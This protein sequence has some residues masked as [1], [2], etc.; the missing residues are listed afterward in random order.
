MDYHAVPPP[1][2][3]GAGF[4]KRQDLCQQDSERVSRTTPGT[5][6][7]GQ[8]EAAGASSSRRPVAA[9]GP[10]SEPKVHLHPNTDAEKYIRKFDDAAKNFKPQSD[11][12]H[13]FNNQ[14]LD[15]KCARLG[16]HLTILQYFP[17]KVAIWSQCT[18]DC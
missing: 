14:V 15:R 5:S 4:S 8:L 7:S 13:E 6:S 9:E 12:E 1:E 16:R 11:E 18:G 17:L 10:S 2:F 3:R